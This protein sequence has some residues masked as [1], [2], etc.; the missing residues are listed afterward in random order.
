MTRHAG[1]WEDLNGKGSKSVAAPVT[2]Q[3]STSEETPPV[4][5]F[6]KN[7]TP[8]LMGLY[9]ALMKLSRMG[10]LTAQPARLLVKLM[11]ELLLRGEKL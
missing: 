9:R 5:P 10:P 2:V 6:E 3:Q 11:Q 4:R 1:T 8:E 7:E